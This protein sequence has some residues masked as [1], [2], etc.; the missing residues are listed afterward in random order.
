[1][2]I[3]SVLKNPMLIISGDGF[4]IYG[5]T[6]GG[7]A[8]VIYCRIKKVSFQTYLD[9]LVLSVALAQGF[10]RIGCFLAGCCY[11]RETDSPFCIVF[12]NSL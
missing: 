5:G 11:G 12:Q 7:I 3:E 8:A 4:V 2:E 1:V 10:G 9:L 6:I